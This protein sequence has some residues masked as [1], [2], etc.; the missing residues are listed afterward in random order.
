MLNNLS[1]R[2][3]FVSIERLL[4][5][6]FI[7][8]VLFYNL[9]GFMRQLRR[10]YVMGVRSFSLFFKDRLLISLIILLL[11]GFVVLVEIQQVPHVLGRL[12]RGF[13]LRI[14][15]PPNQQKFFSPLLL[16]VQNI[17]HAVLSIFAR[18]LLSHYYYQI[19]I[20]I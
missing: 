6:G 8:V 14:A 2:H 16:K 18:L 9:F 20:T 10:M 19:L 5:L 17:P 3:L 12:P 4:L 7:F 1:L 15:L 11:E 13:P